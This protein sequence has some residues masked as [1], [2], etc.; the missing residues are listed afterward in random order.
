MTNVKNCMFL[1]VMHV[2]IIQRIKLMV[3]PINNI[4]LM[5]YRQMF[6][7]RLTGKWGGGG[8]VPPPK[9]LGVWPWNFYQMSISMGRCKICKKIETSHLACKLW[10]CKVQKR[11][12]SSFLEMYLLGVVTW[13][14]FAQLSI[15]TSEI[16]CKN[17]RS[18]SQRLTI[19]QTSII[20]EISIQ[21]SSYHT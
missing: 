20:F 5:V 1:S 13:Q 16:D 8:V 10:V 9:L 12:N 21:N 3:I 4:Q 19:L 2:T 18:I 17:F 6:W 14:N 15:L 11:S 7:H